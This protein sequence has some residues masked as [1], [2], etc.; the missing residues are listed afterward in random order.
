MQV[1]IIQFS[2]ARSCSNSSAI[3]ALAAT[4]YSVFLSHKECSIGKGPYAIKMI[5]ERTAML[6]IAHLF[7]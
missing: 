7:H 2:V 1:R 3:K 4:Q 6:N 5:S